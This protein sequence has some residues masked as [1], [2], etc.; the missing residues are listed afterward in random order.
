MRPTLTWKITG[1]GKRDVNDE[2]GWTLL[3]NGTVLTVDA[4]VFDYHKNGKRYEIYHPSTG[5]W[6]TPGN[7]PVQLWDSY[8][9]A[10]HDRMKSA[11]AF[12]DPTGRFSTSG[13]MALRDKPGT[14]PPTTPR[15]KPG[16]PDTDIPDEMDSA[17]GPATS[18][19]GGNVSVP[20]PAPGIFN[21]GSSVLH[22]AMEKSR[23]ATSRLV[24]RHAPHISLYYGNMLLLPTGEVVGHRLRQRLGFQ[25]WWESQRRMAPADSL[26]A[27]G[28]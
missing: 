27:N 20:A 7:T 2:E 10:N 11:P 14:L 23:T 15:R 24:T 21:T 6:T 9:D 28:R 5:R 13:Q 3:P 16:P 19:P 12:S 1:A 22:L 26:G 25:A 4:Y 18:L 8:P 17:D